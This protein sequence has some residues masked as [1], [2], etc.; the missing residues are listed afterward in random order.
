MTGDQVNRSM[1]SFT[2]T[3][4]R[5]SPNIQYSTYLPIKEYMDGFAMRMA[6]IGAEKSGTKTS[7]ISRYMSDAFSEGHQRNFDAPQKKKLFLNGAVINL[8]L[9]DVPNTKHL[10]ELKF[11]SGVV[12][13]YSSASRESLAAAQGVHAN[14]KAMFPKAVTM[15]LGGMSDKTSSTGDCVSAE[16]GRTFAK[17]I[18]SNLF[19]EGEKKY[20]VNCFSLV[21]LL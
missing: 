1:K 13:G 19:F 18:G 12:V 20:Q 21:S 11:V 15:V 2:R 6:F 17:S 7:F 4:L 10:S 3:M 16:E 14:V 9:V 5:L 8:E